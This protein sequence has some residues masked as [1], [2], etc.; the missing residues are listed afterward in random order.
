MRETFFFNGRNYYRYPNAKQSNHRKYY[1]SHA[2]WKATPRLLHRDIWEFYNGTIPDG[3]EIH[4]EDGDF[5]NNDITNLR[6][7]SN[8]AHQVAHRD[9]RSERARRPEHLAR[10]EVIRP[11]TKAWHASPEGREWHRQHAIKSLTKVFPDQPCLICGAMYRPKINRP[12]MCSDECKRIR[13]ND[14][15]RTKWNSRVRS[16]G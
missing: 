11:L 5:N 7:L 10:L 1:S 16:D 9:E 15:Q 6:C 14:Q 4:H 2:Q 8:A 3:H 12:G 13:R